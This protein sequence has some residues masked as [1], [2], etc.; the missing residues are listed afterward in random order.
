MRKN[1]RPELIQK[2]IEIIL[3]CENED[4]S[5]ITAGWLA[6]KLN[7]SPSNLARAFKKETRDTLQ[8][9]MIRQKILRSRI[10][11]FNHQDIT[12]GKVAA[13]LDYRSTSHFIMAFKKI[14]GVTPRLFNRCLFRE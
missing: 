11:F 14:N 12:V 2:A 13:A 5:F 10:L 6:R 1:E 9:Y 7:T 3:S 8:Q 4:F